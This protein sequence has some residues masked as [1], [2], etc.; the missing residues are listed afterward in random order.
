M[1]SSVLGT[2]SMFSKSLQSACWR[3]PPGSP[4]ATGA[5]GQ[6]LVRGRDDVPGTA[7]ARGV[8]G[9][10]PVGRGQGSLG[11]LQPP[12]AK[13]VLW[14]GERG[15]GVGGGGD[16]RQLEE[17]VQKA[18]MSGSQ[19]EGAR[20]G[21]GKKGVRLA[22]MGLGRAELGEV[23]DRWAP[24][25]A[26]EEGGGTDWTR[27]L[28]APPP[29]PRPHCSSSPGRSHLPG[30]AEKSPSRLEESPCCEG[31]LKLGHSPEAPLGTSPP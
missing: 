26:V 25:R 24:K 9:L 8:I 3:A 5:G 12:P 19:E 10:G 13:L 1:A 6:Y 29:D 11:L 15:V 4:R 20:G 2:L 18:Q 22:E 21:R 28:L 14:G 17:T 30:P 7:D 31:A 27:S 23:L 16:P